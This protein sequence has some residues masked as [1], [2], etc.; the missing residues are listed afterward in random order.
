M[1]FLNNKLKTIFGAAGMVIL[2]GLF[3]V[4]GTAVAST[5]DGETPANEHVCDNLQGSTPGLYGLCVAYCE[6]QDLDVTNK[7]PP[8]TKILE[9]YRKKMQ[10]GDPDMP[11]IMA[12]CPCWSDAELAS[13]TANGVA[14]CLRNDNTPVDSIQLIGI[15][16]YTHFAFA[17]KG[18]RSR[19]AYV[20]LN[21][22]TPII[23]SQ[24]IS[25]EDA[26]VCWNALDQACP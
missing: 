26:T 3:G 1:N 4:S 19:C 10:P 6:A 12:P 25:P 2:A 9:N 13:V 14:A 22:S 17:D 16:T 20:D 7:E 8:N 23:R 15:A 5:P 24:N 21:S 18:A 11:C